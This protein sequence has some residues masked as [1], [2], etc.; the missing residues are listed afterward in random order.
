MLSYYCIILILQSLQ[1][2][3]V[4]FAQ[5]EVKYTLIHSS[6]ADNIILPKF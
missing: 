3:V 5:L 2:Q 1:A 6:L 4:I